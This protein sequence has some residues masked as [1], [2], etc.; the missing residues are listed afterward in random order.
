[1]LSFPQSNTGV[2]SLLIAGQKSATL[3][4]LAQAYFA[5]Q[6]RR[7]KCLFGLQRHGTKC[8]TICTGV[9]RQTETVGDSG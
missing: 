5:V 7:T 8:H 6:L 3:Q 1:M 4:V 9:R 2:L